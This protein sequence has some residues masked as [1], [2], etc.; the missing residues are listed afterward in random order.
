MI[1]EVM[2]ISS[3]LDPLKFSFGPSIVELQFLFVK[4]K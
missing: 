2:K 3:K 4:G 1:I